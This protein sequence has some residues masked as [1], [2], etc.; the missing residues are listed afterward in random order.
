[1]CQV[2]EFRRNWFS[3]TVNLIVSSAGYFIVSF[4][5][6]NA[7]T[8]IITTTLSSSLSD[9]V[10]VLLSGFLYTKLGPRKAF[11]FG[12]IL[13][14]IG[15]SLLLAFWK[16][17]NQPI[18]LYFFIYK[19]GLAQ[20]LTM[21]YFAVVLLIPQAYNTSVF[22]ISN[23]FSRT[24]TALAPII[25]ELSYPTPILINFGLFVLAILGTIPMVEKLPKC[26]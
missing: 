10:G 9:I 17:P 26:I 19:N 18:S 21:N 1:M 6:K 8:D 15:G 2:P 24:I 13:S 20:V 11:W 3:L 4:S 7:P 25:G 5:V 12:Y 16:S 23:F 14:I 22:G